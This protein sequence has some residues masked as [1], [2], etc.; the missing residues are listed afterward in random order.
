VPALPRGASWIERPGPHA[1]HESSRRALLLTVSYPPRTEVGAARWEGFTPFLTRA[2]WGV[3]AVIEE[4]HPHERT[5]MTR[6]ARLPADVRVAETA[7]K[8]AWWHAALLGLRGALKRRRGTVAEAP[9]AFD[10]VNRSS[11]GAGGVRTVLHAAVHVWRA[12]T[13][14]EDFSAVALALADTRHRVVISSGPPHYVHVAASRVRYLQHRIDHLGWGRDID[15]IGR[16]KRLRRRGC[17]RQYLGRLRAGA[18]PRRH[19]KQAR[20]QPLKR[21]G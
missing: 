17:S 9:V 5:D 2:G 14:L 4:R 3:D 1:E 20:Y 21:F 15:H 12:R 7:H 10:E 11:S 19:Q 18:C 16:P 6:L 13:G 8:R